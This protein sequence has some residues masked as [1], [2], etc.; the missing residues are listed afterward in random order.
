LN[1]TK[2]D[3][4]QNTLGERIIHSVIFSL[5]K[6]IEPGDFLQRSK[7][8]LSSISGVEKFMVLKQVNKNNKFNF[9]FYMEFKNQKV[10]EEYSNH[11][12]HLKYVKNIWLNEVEDFFEIDFAE[13]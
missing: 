5:K 13:I 8:L 12:E 6:E 7:K 1:N 2:Q 4:I 10:Y 3:Q 11:P 9:G